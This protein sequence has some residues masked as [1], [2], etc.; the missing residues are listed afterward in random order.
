MNLTD[1]TARRLATTVA[2][3]SNG[4]RVK[5]GRT[6]GAPCLHIIVTREGH[7]ASTT[8]FSESEWD[9]HRE[10]A[11]NQRKERPSYHD[12]PIITRAGLASA[13]ANRE[14]Q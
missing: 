4:V 9:A 1:D 8:I 10:N 11:A 2:K 7:K 13:I 5:H 3:Q 14:A 12:E 6:N